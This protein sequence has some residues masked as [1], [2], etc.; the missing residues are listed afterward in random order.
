MMLRRG[1]ILN[2]GDIRNLIHAARPLGVPA[3][4]E[5]IQRRGLRRNRLIATGLLAAMA[6]LFV[7]T[8][9]PPHPGFSILLVRATAEAALV[10][11]LADWFAVTALFRQPLGLPIPHTAILPKNKDRIGEGLAI[12]IERN[13][14]SPD[15]VRAKLRS[16][17][18]ARFV[19]DWLSEPTNADAVAHRLVRMLPHLIGAIDDRDFRELVGASLG[20]HLAEIDLAPLFGRVLGV[21][22][23]NGFHEIL[24]DRLL[25][26]CRQ[27]VED[28]EEQLYMAAEAQRRRWW[29]PKT[30]NR[31]I[32]KAIVG[33]VKELLSK[34]REPDSPARRNLLQGIERLVNQLS[35]SSAYR[36]R[37]EEVKLRLLD[38]QE[39]KAWLGS[40]W[41]DVKRAMQADLASRQS[42]ADRMLST[43][44]LSLGHHLRGDAA[45]RKRLNRTIEAM[46]MEVVPWRAALGQFII[47][48]VR[49]WDAG[50][51]TNRLELVVGR[52]LQYIRITG[53]LV[54]GF[55]GCLL[56][57]VSTALE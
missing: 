28:R 8:T 19:A 41:D 50:S 47:E 35:T 43:A 21:L 51:F 22:R 37:I 26:F 54:G 15:I 14:L 57:L 44:A 49:Q 27:F 31:Q 25:D 30:V 18:P 32:A 12:F 1:M 2:P 34:L 53:T 29:I 23:A 16:I 52:D 9:L 36:D 33:G 4:D 6:A 20:R 7:I 42:R 55:V 11:G 3:T 5:D 39:V 10:G 40:V 24:L 38:D 45:M 48:V 13:F 46:A 56:Y 17:D